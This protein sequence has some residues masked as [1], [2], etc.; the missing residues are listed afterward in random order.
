MASTPRTVTRVAGSLL[1]DTH[2]HWTIDSGHLD[3]TSYT[4]QLECA[5]IGGGT[6]S[7]SKSSGITGQV[8]SSSVPSIV[9]AW[10][11]GDLGTL[12]AGQYVCELTGT[13][14][15]KDLKGQFSLIVTDQV[16]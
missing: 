10:L 3:G 12:A 5:P 7:F 11:A 1:P 6:L 8:G 16:S 14:G 4:W 15:G 2:V 9:I 13:S